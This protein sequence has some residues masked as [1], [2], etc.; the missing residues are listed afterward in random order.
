MALFKIYAGPPNTTVWWADS[1]NLLAAYNVWVANVVL[2][3]AVVIAGI[4]M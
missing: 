4:V 2:A 3:S 1:T